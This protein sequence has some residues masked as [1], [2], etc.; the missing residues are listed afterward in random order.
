MVD[1]VGINCSKIAKIATQYKAV[2]KRMAV[3]SSLPDSVG[4]NGARTASMFRDSCIGQGST[5]SVCTLPQ[6]REKHNVNLSA[7]LEDVELLDRASQVEEEIEEKNVLNR[8]ASDKKI[9]LSEE[10]WHAFLQTVFF[11]E[12]ILLK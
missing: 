7:Q 10:R 9:F 11:R 12:M 1:T 3:T 2:L 6:H 4:E 8:Y 5:F